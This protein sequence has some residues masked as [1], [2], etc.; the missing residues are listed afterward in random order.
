MSKELG[1][2]KMV[3]YKCPLCEKIFQIEKENS[4]RDWCEE[5]AKRLKNAINPFADIDFNTLRPN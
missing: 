1:K 3:S 5:C 4:E 2:V